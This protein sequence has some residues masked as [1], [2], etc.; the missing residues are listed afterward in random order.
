[1][2]STKFKIEDAFGDV[3]RKDSIPP[4]KITKLKNFFSQNSINIIIKIIFFKPRKK[5]ILI[6]N[7]VL[8]PNM[9]KIFY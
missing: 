8:L 7:R 4:A 3:I 6:I 9:N 1:M 5:K 2:N